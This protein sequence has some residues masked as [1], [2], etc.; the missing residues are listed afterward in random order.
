MKFC[1][2]DNALFWKYHGGILLNSLLKEEA[3]KAMEEFHAGDCGGH[4]YWK[5]NADKILRTI[6]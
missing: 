6:F 3:D 1:I 4:L 2:I 5:T